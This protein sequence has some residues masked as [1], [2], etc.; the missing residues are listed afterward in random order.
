MFSLWW[1]AFSTLWHVMCTVWWAALHGIWCLVYDEQRSALC[2]MWCLVYGEQ[3][4]ALC[5]MWCL[6]YDEQCLALHMRVLCIFPNW[7]QWKWLHPIPL[8]VLRPP[9]HLNLTASAVI[10]SLLIL[11]GWYP[12]ADIEKCGKLLGLCSSTCLFDFFIFSGFYFTEG[13]K[14]KFL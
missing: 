5:G 12:L 4:S 7:P 2:G 14:V 3:H 6:L 11:E 1:A 10:L 9:C 13:A 8:Y